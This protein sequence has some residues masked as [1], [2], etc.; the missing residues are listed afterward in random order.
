MAQ[1]PEG[2]PGPASRAAL[3]PSRGHWDY[4]GTFQVVLPSVLPNSLGSQRTGPGTRREL[5]S[6]VVMRRHPKLRPVCRWQ[7]HTS[8]NLQSMAPIRGYDHTS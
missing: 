5:R 8:S 3:L 7:L 6:I 2:A 4:S 1:A